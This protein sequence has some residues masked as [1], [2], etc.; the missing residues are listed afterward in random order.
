MEATKAQIEL[1]KE[2]F[3][4]EAKNMSLELSRQILASTIENLFDKKEQETLIKKGLT[5][6]KSHE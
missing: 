3:K 6:I 4:K 1:E 5:K 2:N